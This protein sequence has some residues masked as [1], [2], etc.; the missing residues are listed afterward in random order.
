MIMSII[1][2]ITKVSFNA[3]VDMVGVIGFSLL[4]ISSCT[5][6][7]YLMHKHLGEGSVIMIILSQTKDQHHVTLCKIKLA[8]LC[9]LRLYREELKNIIKVMHYS[10]NKKTNYLFWKK[11]RKYYRH[12][13]IFMKNI[14]TN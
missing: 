12:F 1:H 2:N 3:F 6:C 13:L 5:K 4:I 8:R 10:F 14:M 11:K 7:R 9:W